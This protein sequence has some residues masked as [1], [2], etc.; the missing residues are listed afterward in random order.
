MSWLSSA[1]SPST[2]ARARRRGSTR[3]NRA[4]ARVISSS[5]TPTQRPESTL[6]PA[7]TRRSIPV[8]TNRDDQ[9]VAAPSPAPAR[10][11]SRT[12]AGVLLAAILVHSLKAAT[13]SDVCD[14]NNSSTT[15]LSAILPRVVFFSSPPFREGSSRWPLPGSVSGGGNTGAAPGPTQRTPVTITVP[16]SKTPMACKCICTAGRRLPRSGCHRPSRP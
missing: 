9:T 6:R 12:T 8:V 15:M 2:N 10:R 14:S 3:P 4:P 11:R 7:A 5:S 13:G 1:S 16:S